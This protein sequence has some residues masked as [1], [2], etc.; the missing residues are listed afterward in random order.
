MR[1]QHPGGWMVDR[2]PAWVP[3]A[4]VS[5]GQMGAKFDGI[6]WNPPEAEKHQWCVI[7]G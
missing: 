1:L 2:I 6:Y 4:T 3:W 5:P 7:Q